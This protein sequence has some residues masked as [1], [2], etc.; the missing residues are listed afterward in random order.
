MDNEI[1]HDQTTR[2]LIEEAFDSKRL[3]LNVKSTSAGASTTAKGE[4]CYLL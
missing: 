4:R 3:L 1:S 2:F